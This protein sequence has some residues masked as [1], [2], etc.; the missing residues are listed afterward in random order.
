MPE[1]HRTAHK[2]YADPEFL[3]PRKPNLDSFARLSLFRIQKDAFADLAGKN[4]E[5]FPQKR[6]KHSF[7]GQQHLRGV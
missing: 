5:Y 6:K 1:Q 3:K 7:G 2:I 4:L